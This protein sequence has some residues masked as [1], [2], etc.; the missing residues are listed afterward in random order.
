[1]REVSVDFSSSPHALRSTLGAPRVLTDKL[2]LDLTDT[3]THGRFDVVERFPGDSI[4]QYVAQI[5]GN[6]A[7]RATLLAASM[8]MVLRVAIVLC[9]AIGPRKFV[10]QFGITE[11]FERVVDGGETQAVNHGGHI[12]VELIGRGMIRASAQGFV[13]GAPLSR[14]SEV[15]SSEQLVD[16]VGYF[17]IHAHNARVEVEA[18]LV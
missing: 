6:I 16:V 17:A 4:E 15:M 11:S 1:M 14:A 9:A 2:D 5:V 12:L 18:A 7:N 13:Y 8:Q 3:K 10:G